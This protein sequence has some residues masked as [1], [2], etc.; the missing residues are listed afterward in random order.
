MDGSTCSKKLPRTRGACGA[1]ERF[2]GCAP[3]PLFCFHCTMA[4]RAWRGEGAAAAS[5]L[6]AWP[7]RLALVHQ[8]QEK[9][10]LE[11][12]VNYRGVY[13]FKVDASGA[14]TFWT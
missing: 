4:G 11:Q 6:T 5:L 3:G 8:P 7:C 10:K 13:I 2:S 1:S 14:A 12:Q 9:Q